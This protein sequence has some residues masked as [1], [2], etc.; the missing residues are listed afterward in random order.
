[1]KTK[2]FTI[3]S[4]LALSI[5]LNAQVPQKALDVEESLAYVTKK[6]NAGTVGT[7]TAFSINEDAGYFIT[8]AHCLSQGRPGALELDGTPVGVARSYP[9]LDIMVLH[10][11]RIRKPQVSTNHNPD[12]GSL[13][14]AFGY[15]YG[16]GSG[17]VV[18][19]GIVSN[20]RANMRA[21][22]N[23]SQ[24]WLVYDNSNLSGMSG[25][26]LVDSYGNVIGVIIASN[27]RDSINRPIDIVIEATRSYWDFPEASVPVAEADLPDLRRFIP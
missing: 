9:D 23:P 26:P 10:S 22:G 14:W 18:R 24:D 3:V 6:V 27:D 2:L 25:G 1:M 8:A 11:D 4:I 5:G 15:P 19:S 17:A 13:A 20:P 12:K 7:C 21:Q 16:S